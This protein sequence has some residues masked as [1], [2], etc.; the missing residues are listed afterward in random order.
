[1]GINLLMH[2]INLWRD[3]LIRSSVVGTIIM[4][5]KFLKV[6][7]WWFGQGRQIR[8]QSKSLF[9]GKQIASRSKV[10]VVP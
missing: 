8:V 2:F 6:H 1:M 3:V 10:A 5:K 9:Q 7:A 4:A